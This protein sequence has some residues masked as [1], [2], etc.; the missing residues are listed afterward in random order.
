MP[1]TEDR[2]AAL[3]DEVSSFATRMYAARLTSPEAQQILA[4]TQPTNPP[5]GQK[6]SHNKLQTQPTNPPLLLKI[7]VTLF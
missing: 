6:N 5:E 2:M 3:S 4:M 7:R 1:S